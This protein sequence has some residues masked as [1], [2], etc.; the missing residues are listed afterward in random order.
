LKYKGGLAEGKFD[1]FGQQYWDNGL[2]VYAG[3]WFGGQ[4]HGTGKLFVD[5]D[6]AE[7]KSY[8]TKYWKGDLVDLEVK[9]DEFDKPRMFDALLNGS[10][11]SFR[12]L[13]G[14]GYT[15]DRIVIVHLELAKVVYDGDFAKFSV[16]YQG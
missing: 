14:E 8:E 11:V 15:T 13:D 2:L 4:K 12:E 10:I 9:I 1:G 5:G 3:E 16:M 7:P 6:S